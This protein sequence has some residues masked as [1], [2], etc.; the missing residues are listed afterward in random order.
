MYLQAVRKILDHLETTQSG[1]IDQAASLSAHA[2][3][4]GGIVYCHDIGHSNQHDFLNRAGGLAALQGFSFS[5][6]VTE[7]TPDCLKERPGG[8]EV[9]RDLE[10]VRLAVNSSKLR[11]GDV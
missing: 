7:P 8:R 4:N 9:Q 6:S 5:F 10:M 2:L 1:A 11:A 3:S